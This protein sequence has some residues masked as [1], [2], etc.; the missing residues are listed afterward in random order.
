MAKI[1]DWVEVKSNGT[2]GVV[3]QIGDL[4]TV[5]VPQTDWPFPKYVEVS[6]NDIKLHRF[7]KHQYEEALL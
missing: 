6:R 1:D 4:V 3:A 7:S 5:R 2:V